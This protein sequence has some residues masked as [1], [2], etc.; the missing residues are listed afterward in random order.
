MTKQQL[1]DV[2]DE[3][4]KDTHGPASFAEIDEYKRVR[5]DVQ[6]EQAVAKYGYGGHAARAA[7]MD[8]VHL[9]YLPT[10]DYSHAV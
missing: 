1:L 3:L 8:A 6:I 4:M 10:H 5:R 9:E 2:W 7:Y